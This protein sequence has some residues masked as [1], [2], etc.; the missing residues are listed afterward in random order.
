MDWNSIL[1]VEGF[2]PESREACQALW[3]L[4]YGGR[5][6]MGN[7]F[8]FWRRSLNRSLYTDPTSFTD[9]AGPDSIKAVFLLWAPYG[10]LRPP[11]C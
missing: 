5:C 7:V 2:S 1:E 6:K 3:F 4:L 8:S 11:A 9:M 10:L